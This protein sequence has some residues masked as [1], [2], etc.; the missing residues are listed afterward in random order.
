MDLSVV[1]KY[2]KEKLISQGIEVSHLSRIFTKKF[3]D[4]V[5]FD[6]NPR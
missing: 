3:S 2:Y 6:Q 1:S 4:E 5:T